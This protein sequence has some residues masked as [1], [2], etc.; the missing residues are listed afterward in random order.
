MR[1]GLRPTLLVLPAL[2]GIAGCATTI[3]PASTEHT[4][5]SNIR[6][7]GPLEARSVACP[8]GVKQAQGVS[9]RCKLTLFNTA[10]G[11]TGSG[12]ITVHEIN[13]GHEIE[14]GPADVHVH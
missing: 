8:G 10:N 13:G 11:A 2:F 1:R 9:F 12:T 14:F 3:D 5:A 7:F 6:K 4:I